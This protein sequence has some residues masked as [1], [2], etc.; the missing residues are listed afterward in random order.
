MIKSA[1]YYREKL[2]LS[3]IPI[4]PGDK[5][6]MVK[7]EK[8]QTELPTTD[9]VKAWWAKT[10]T[11]NIGI[12]TGKIND[13]VV[14]D[15]DRHKPEYSE[16]I[17]L[18]YFPDSILTPT[19]KTPSGGLHMYFKNPDKEMTN[20]ASVLPAIDFRGNG[21]YVVAPPSVNSN[22]KHYEWI[23]GLKI[24]EADFSVL[25]TEYIK[26]VFKKAL[27]FTSTSITCNS[28]N[29]AK[30]MQLFQP[31]RRDNDLFHLANHLIKSKMPQEEIYQYLEFIA[32]KCTP[33]Y[34]EKDIPIKI[35]SAL[36]RTE[37]Q[38]KNLSQEIRDFVLST[39]GHFL[40]TEVY[41]CLLLSTRKEKK[42]CSKVLSELA[43]EKIIE[44]TGSKNGNFRLISDEAP[45]I[46][47]Y[48]P[49]KEFL[50]L[51][52]PL[53][54]HSYY[55]AM[56]KNIIIIAGTQDA[57]KTAFLLRF[58]AMNMNRG[59][60]IRY[61]TSEMGTAEL[62]NRLEMFED[63]PMNQWERV[64]FK[65]NSSNFQDYILP[66]GINVIDYLEVTDNFY[67]VGSELKKIFDRLETGI[68]VIGLQKDFKA[69]L[70][71]GGTFSLEKPRLYV[72]LTSNPP[73]GGIA[74]IVKCKNW[75]DKRINPNG[76]E[77]NF[78]IRDGN[79]IRQVTKWDYYKGLSK[80]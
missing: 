13:L 45:D 35:K 47:I 25:P 1:L 12:V 58:V 23:D 21:G 17:A 70:G 24:T 43:K 9:E 15:F 66:N 4:I 34:P 69:E 57:G 64:N 72:S 32:Q 78:K 65:E 27:V 31:G 14:V 42:L 55:H 18:E 74:K 39:S 29:H 63:I 36:K 80:K 7:W 62:Q 61:Q 46:D 68:A 67:L 30:L 19:A 59:M 71:R 6:P 3:I 79:Q 11:A 51:Q 22:G 5:K 26:Y 53:E 73:E 76:R 28:S 50:K 77:C 16:E 60:K 38:E 54:L 41:N 33:P 48:A 20:N 56:P 2:N 75:A 49:K 37:K 10:P 8:Y 44:R 40:S 52:F